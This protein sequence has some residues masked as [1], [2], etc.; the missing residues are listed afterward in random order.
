MQ[1]RNAL[2]GAFVIGGL[3]LFG[4]GLFL[5]GDRRL[6]FV[7]QF[8]VTSTLVED[9]GKNVDQLTIT[10]NA[11]VRSAQSALNE[12][13]AVVAD[14]RAGHGTLGRLV[15]DDSLY[16]RMVAISDEVEQ[17]MKNVR[18]MTDRTRELVASLS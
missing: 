3:L 16:V 4:G 9:V 5:I 14:V 1:T 6:R 13:T 2:V 18:E 11:A 12:A 15:A 17:S 10:G 8:E 7:R